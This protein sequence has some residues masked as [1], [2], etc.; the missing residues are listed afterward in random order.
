MHGPGPQRRKAGVDVEDRLFAERPDGS[1]SNTGGRS[2]GGQV[3]QEFAN[4]IG[5]D[6][7]Q[8]RVFSQ[9]SLEF[10]EAVGIIGDGVDT[11][12]AGAGVEQVAGDGLG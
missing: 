4:V 3:G 7:G 12:V 2:G 9:E 11:Q 8:G 5:G 10:A 1:G 6:A